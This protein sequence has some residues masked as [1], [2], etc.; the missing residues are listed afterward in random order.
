MGLKKT[1]YGAARLLWLALVFGAWVSL[2]QGYTEPWLSFSD[3]PGGSEGAVAIGIAAGL[4]GY[5]LISVLHRGAEHAEWEK[6]GQQAGL[7][8]GGDA[9]DTSGPALTGTVDGRTV[10]ASYDK[11]KKSSGGQGSTRVM[12][13]L[14][15]ADLAGPTDQ[16][17]VVG[18][19]GSTVDAGVGTID[20][21]EMAETVSAADGL[22]AAEAGGLVVLGTSP[23]A[24]EA[25]ADGSSGDALRAVRGLEI[26]AVGDAAGIVGRWAEARNAELEAA[27]NSVGQHRVDNLV[28]RVPG[29]P[30]TVTVETRGSI[31]NG[32]VLRRFAEGAVATADAFEGATDHT[33]PVE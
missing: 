27:G 25:V 8:P 21:D 6:T 12:F 16:G 33:P 7:R 29:D 26:A 17:V 28:E 11:R 10:T 13:T 4:V 19:A 18:R 20:F 9:G 24:V 23:A 15:E 14:C 31:R 5:L 22:V 32:D 3:I 2:D 30:A 1:F